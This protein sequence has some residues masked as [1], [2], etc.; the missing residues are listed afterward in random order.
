MPSFAKSTNQSERAVSRAMKLTARHDSR[1]DGNVHSIGTARAYESALDQV[2]KW[3]R[4]QG[5]V[6]LDRLTTEQAQA[7]LAERSEDLSQ[8]TLD[9][10]RQALQILPGVDKL[11]RVKSEVDR[12]GLADRGRAYTPA[13]VQAIAAAQTEKNALATEIAHAA[14]LRAHELLTIRPL[15]EQ[16]ASG[17]RTWSA[18]RFAGRE[19]VPYSV[20]GKGGLIREVQ[21]P[22][23]LAQR[24]EARRLDIPRNVT[25]RGVRYQTHYNIGGGNAWSSSFSKVSKSELGYSTGAHG[26]RHS[27]AQQRMDELQGQGRQYES[28]LEVV[29]QEMGH[30]RPDITEVYLR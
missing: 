23:D 12:P 29:S 17:H 30:F 26:L 3:D 20:V 2:A 10:H 28:S 7:Y 1:N 16:P 14:G 25:D 13:Q 11:D 4:A 8:S 9:L 22:A 18:E 5:G 27:Y 6:G 21:I 24:L 15:S 19:G